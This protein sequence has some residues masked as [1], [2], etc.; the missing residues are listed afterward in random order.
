VT[1][2][3]ASFDWDVDRVKEDHRILAREMN[4]LIDT[5][6]ALAGGPPGYATTSGS[7][8]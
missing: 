2:R 5:Q 4:A 3:I 1:D 7:A 8:A 6:R